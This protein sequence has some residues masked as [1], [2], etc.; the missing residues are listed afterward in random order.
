MKKKL[1]PT[2][3][4]SLLILLCGCGNVEI[5]V[6]PEP[7]HVVE[8]S[9]S[10]M[11]T[12]IYYVKNGTKFA[13]VYLPK[14][15]VKGEVKSV[16]PS[17]VLYF[18]GDEKMLPT[19]Y[20]GELIAYASA[21]A[22]LD[23]ICLE[24]F[25]DMGYS[26]GIYGGE[27]Q[28]DGYYHISVRK[29]LAEQS[30][31]KDVFSKVV[32]D[33]IRIT[34]VGGSPVGELI[35]AGS[36]IITGLEKGKVY[37]VEFYSGTYFYRQN[38][39]ADTHFLRAFEVY[40][41]GKESIDDTTHGYMCFNT[42]EDLKSGYYL[43]NGQG[44]FLYH[45]YERGQENAEEDVNEGY[46]EN[47]EQVI[48]SYSK[49]YTVSVPT[50]TRDMKINVKYGSITKGEDANA[51]IRGCVAS[52]EGVLYDM[53]NDPQNM[54]LTLTLS[55]AMAGDWTVYITPK[56]LEVEGVNVQSD[57][58]LEETVCES[59]SFT[60]E[61]DTSYQ[62]F[63]ADIEGT[64]NVYGSVIGP[65][66]ITYGLE[67]VTYRDENKESQRYMCYRLPYVKKGEYIV[68]IYHYKSETKISN[69]KMMSYDE[70]GSEIIIIE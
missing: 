42:P 5:F 50:S 48:A 44:L 30:D 29:N 63:Y 58:M 18:T 52:P 55:V 24:R 49:Q 11:K 21:K 7:D 26:I 36:G 12:E 33:E 56:S 64:G 57:Q 22:D 6:Q 23:N 66:G 51:E 25:K 68:N 67:V 27:M 28:E 13:K 43:V 69:I 61:E 8:I 32:S 53:E 54:T 46:Y 14:G 9:D 2:I 35:D 17:R 47:E 37:T 20:R 60:V 1:I 39:T 31:A 41:Y 3:L 40:N 19:H 15:N 70:S 4:F 59:A 10:Q 16:K 38:F 62:M 34:T 65:D 45:D